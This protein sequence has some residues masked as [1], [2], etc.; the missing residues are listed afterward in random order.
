MP[1]FLRLLAFNFIHILM[2]LV[3]QMNGELT[4]YP[5]DIKLFE[6]I[7]WV[8]PSTQIVNMNINNDYIFLLCILF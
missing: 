1:A 7:E 8:R 6:A 4:G 5:M 3:V 2:N